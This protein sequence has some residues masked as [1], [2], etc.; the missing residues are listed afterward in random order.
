VIGANAVPL[1]GVFTRGWSGATALSLYWFENLVGSLLIAVRIAAHEALTH[2]RGHRRRQLNL[3]TENVAGA[4]RARQRPTPKNAYGEPRT[5]LREFLV[6]ACMATGVHG[7]VLWSVVRKVLESAP[8]RHA[9]LQG[10]LGIGAFQVLGFV[11]DMI[12]IR[13]RPF[14]SLRDLANAGIRRV[15]LIHLVMIVGFWV[16]LRGGASGF[17]GPFAVIKTAADVGNLLAMA[18]FRADPE[19]APG[20]LA[21]AVNRIGPADPRDGDFATYWRT[22][23]E[24]ERALAEADEQVAAAPAARRRTRRRSARARGARR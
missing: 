17:F 5:F 19:E 20:W 22:R 16:A 11:N 14:A 1:I 13:E 12:G 8:D 3:N 23:K 24:E 9:L 4:D 18:G 21:A 10:C 6:A 7:L 2:K 15:T